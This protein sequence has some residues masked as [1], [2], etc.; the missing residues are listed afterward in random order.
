MNTT[1]TQKWVKNERAGGGVVIPCN[2][3]LH[4]AKGESFK[5]VTRITNAMRSIGSS[6][7]GFEDMEI[8]V[9]I[10]IHFWYM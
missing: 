10:K 6:I 7:D 4:V 5:K 9:R 3:L 1:G 2:W 8:R